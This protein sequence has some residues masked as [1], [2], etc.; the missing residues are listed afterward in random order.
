LLLQII[1]S[2]LSGNKIIFKKTCEVHP[3]RFYFLN[4]GGKMAGDNTTQAV[5][6]L[7]DLVDKNKTPGV[8]Y[9][10]T[11]KGV[12]LFEHNTGMAEFETNKRIS[13]KSFFNACS[14]TKTFTSLGIMQLAE[15][16][17]IQLSDN[18]ARYMNDYPFSKQ[19]TIQQLL[20]HTS[21]LSNPIP[22]RWAHL[23]EEESTFNYDE[24][25]ND[26]LRSHAKLISEPGEKFSY[27][28]LNYLMLGK[29]IQKVSGMNFCDY[30]LQNIIAKINRN[31]L[32]LQFL[33]TDETNYAR[34]YQKRFSFINGILGFLL[35]RKKF[36]ERSSNN[37]W[38][39]F[40]K[41]YVSGR[42][43]GG[44]IANAY[45]LTAFIEALFTH[46]SPL[47]SEPYKKILFTKQNTNNGKAIEMTLG[48][49]I[50]KLKNIDYFTHAGGGGGYYCEM[51]MYPE[52]NLTTAIMFNRSGI[53]DERFLD[54]ID[55]FFF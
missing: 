9:T 51:R 47:L 34:G 27:S 48:W 54:K 10:V 52:K 11:S 7:N 2:A 20:S 3:G 36:T 8:Q 6:F 17:K 13:H 40:K 1:L 15:K 21:G 46:N 49:F 5:A 31:D 29:I 45:S 12:V 23:Q 30:I 14:V 50:G 32:P 37:K 43:Y 42:A 4:Q 44:L 25:V 55:H 35:D 33:L 16:E 24:F 41:Y 38:V 18:A 22:L 26:V 28:N 39:K 19:I 53:S